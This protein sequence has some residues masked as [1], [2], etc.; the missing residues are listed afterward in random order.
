ME[1]PAKLACWSVAIW[2]R[3]VLAS[4][5]NYSG[6]FAVPDIG[7]FGEVNVLRNGLKW[8]KRPGRLI[9][10]AKFTL[11]L[12][13]L[14]ALLAALSCS[15]TNSAGKRETLRLATLPLE[16]GTLVFVAEDQG[17]FTGNSLN[18]E[19]EY[20]DTGL[21]TLN[22]LLD[23]EADLAVP[24][25]EYALVGKAFD[26]AEIKTIGAI[27]KTDYQVIASRKDS[28]I[29]RAADLKGKKIGVIQ[30]TQQEF[31]LTRFLELNNIKIA[32]VSIVNI[33]LAGSV[34]A[35]VNSTVDAVMLVPPYTLTARERLG[36]NVL[37][38]PAQSNRLTHQLII[39]TNAWLSQN[40]E[41][42]KR[43]LKSLS[44]ARDFLVH[45]PDKA[46]AIVKERLSLTETDIERIW[47]QNRFEL[48]LDRSLIAAMED[49]ARWM[50][51][52]NMIVSD[53]VPVFEEYIYPDGLLEV[54]P[55]AVTIVQ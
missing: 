19:T 34:G 14:L 6:R 53:T 42:V 51:E 38:W 52:N 21:G 32:E 54:Q 25:G 28:G 41:A 7:F 10:P 13:M 35:L 44:Q 48:S 2:G 4:E 55:D 47:A 16:T 5:A 30:K 39:C 15:S 27:D 49:E 18:L 8:F 9:I 29:T 31:F 36:S 23:G 11:V 20:Y 33:D 17:Y 45:N 26:K 40:P 46:K 3:N 22:A 50:I 1:P 24:V 43:F 37:F 12:L